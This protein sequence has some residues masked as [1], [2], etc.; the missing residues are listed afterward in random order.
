MHSKPNINSLLYDLEPIILLRKDFTCMHVHETRDTANQSDVT[1]SNS[2]WSRWQHMRS[3]S[4]VLRLHHI[5]QNRTYAPFSPKFGDNIPAEINSLDLMN[6]LKHVM[7]LCAGIVTATP[8]HSTLS[9]TDSLVA[10]SN[11][12][13]MIDSHIT[14]CLSTEFLY[15]YIMSHQK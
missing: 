5:P 3:R 2:Y 7:Y 6:I 13:Q 1:E 11:T 9:F 14:T 15:L 10:Y 8:V 4:K 12:K